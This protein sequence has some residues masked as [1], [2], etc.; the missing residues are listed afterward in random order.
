MANI[1]LMLNS[2]DYR[3]ADGTFDGQA[4]H[5]LTRGLDAR[6]DTIGLDELTPDE[7]AGVDLEIEFSGAYE[8]L[9]TLIDRYVEDPGTAPGII[10]R[11]TNIH[12]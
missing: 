1:V 2:A 9:L 8:D 10:A 4:L 6:F 3:T 5:E 11:I 12:D 7:L